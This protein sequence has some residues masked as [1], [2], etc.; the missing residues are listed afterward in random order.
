M[1]ESLVSVTS[2]GP[3]LDA[4]TY[5][6]RLASSWE[7]RYGKLSFRGRLAALAECLEDRD[8]IGTKWLDA[9]CGT[10]TLSRWMADRGCTVIGVDAAPQMINRAAGLANSGAS[11]GR[12]RFELV[13]T[14]A[15]LPLSSHSTDGVLCS[16]VLEYVPDPETC[17]TEFARVLRPGGILL[18]SVPNSTSLIRR[19]Q[20]CCS[21]LGQV[22]GVDWVTYLRYSKN[23]YSSAHFQQLLQGLGFSLDRVIAFGGSLPR[24]MQRTHTWGPLLMFSAIK[25]RA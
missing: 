6:D 12:L 13:E 15:R 5:H 18:V 17:L 21:R 4:V 7:Q 16:S 9:G 24:C 8:L 2:F 10:G 22:L 20:T 11:P 25:R 14:I 19:A 23:Q 1:G 3:A